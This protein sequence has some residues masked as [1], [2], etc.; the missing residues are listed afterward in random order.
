MALFGGQEITTQQH[1]DIEDIREDMI[2]LKNGVVSLV[3]ETTALNFDLLSEEE[4]DARIVAFARVLNSLTFPLQILIST[5]RKDVS[6]Y[7]QKLSVHKERQISPALKRQIEIYMQF[8]KN[9]TVRNEVL[10]KRFFVAIPTVVGEVSRT[11][12]WKQ[13][14]GKPVKIRNVP[15]VL[16]KA[17]T[18]L[19]PKRDHIIKQLKKMQIHARQLNSDE[20]IKLFYSFYDPDRAGLERL[21]IR[22]DEI[23]SGLVTALT[24]EGEK[25]LQSRQQGEATK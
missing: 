7:V 20:L 11:S 14:F 15:Q 8:V 13:M 2:L 25:E 3:L 12:I 10:D 18:Q 4:Q 23:T 9:L 16:E 17:R 24:D 6:S 21:N 5:Q 1:L 19:L 22:S